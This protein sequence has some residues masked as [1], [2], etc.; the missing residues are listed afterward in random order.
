MGSGSGCTEQTATSRSCRSAERCR[1]GDQGSTTPS[2][3]LEAPLVLR[4][5]AAHRRWLIGEE[6]GTQGRVAAPTPQRA[7]R[8]VV[9]VAHDTAIAPHDHAAGLDGAVV[10]DVGGPP[11]PVA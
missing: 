2:H 10:V 9:Q 8:L 5:T 1:N 11:R 4:A 3:V 6:G 7:E